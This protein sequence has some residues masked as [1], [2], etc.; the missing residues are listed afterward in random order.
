MNALPRHIQ[1]QL[2][3]ANALEASLA[4]RAAFAD[5]PATSVAA[6]MAPA[7]EIPTPVPPVSPVVLHAATEA[8]KD[9]FEHKYRVLQGMY[10]ADITRVKANQRDLDTRLAA[11]ER[12]PAATPAQPN[13]QDL[14]KFGA[15]LIDMV[16]RYAEGQQAGVEARLI[17]LEQK[18]GVVQSQAAATTKKS[19]LQELASMVPDFKEINADQR[20]LVWLG[21]VDDVYGVPRQAALDDAQAKGDV[22]RVANVFKAFRASLPVAPEPDVGLAQQVQPSSVGNPPAPRVPTKQTITQKAITDFYNDVSRGKYSGRQ[23]EAD[24]LEMQINLA[25]AENRVV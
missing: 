23:A 11:I 15:D 25:V 3:E 12:A 24:A 13:E 2:D 4:Q 8:P 20:W 17:A 22:V 7:A 6:L 5:Q 19:F 16:K 21:A 10:E 14:D 18:V 1:R 9:D